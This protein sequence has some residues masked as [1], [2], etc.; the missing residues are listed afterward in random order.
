MPTLSELIRSI[1]HGS[2]ESFLKLIDIF[3]KNYLFT[4]RKINIGPYVLVRSCT[5]MLIDELRNEVYVLVRHS[6]DIYEILKLNI[7]LNVENE[8]EICETICTYLRDI[9]YGILNTEI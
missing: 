9:A 4:T 2:V 3:E 6:E 5:Y 8:D 7:K 1:R